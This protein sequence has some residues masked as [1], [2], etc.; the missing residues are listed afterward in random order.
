[1]GAQH[2][3]LD[4]F[5]RPFHDELHADGGGQVHDGVGL[6]GQPVQH[7]GVGEVVDGKAVERMA[8]ERL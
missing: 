3:G 8:G 4:G 5:G 6:A 1:M 7:Q 2:V